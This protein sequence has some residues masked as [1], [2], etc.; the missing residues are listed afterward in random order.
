MQHMFSRHFAAIQIMNKNV[1][2][3]YIL[4]ENVKRLKFYIEAFK[5]KILLKNKFF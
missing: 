5:I 4:I 1:N 2:A 3:A